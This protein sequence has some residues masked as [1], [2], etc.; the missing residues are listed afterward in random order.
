MEECGSDQL[1]S[2]PA[3]L[4]L[5]FSKEDTNVQQDKC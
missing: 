2:E 1:T 3:E 4:E 5:P